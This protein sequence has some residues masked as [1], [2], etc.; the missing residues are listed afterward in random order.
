VIKRPGGIRFD[1]HRPA[2]AAP[3]SGSGPAPGWYPRG[4]DTA[5]ATSPDGQ[6]V[7]V[8]QGAVVRLFTLA[9]E[10]AGVATL[11]S[12]DADLAIVGPPTT[13]VVIERTGTGEGGLGGETA[14]IALAVPGLGE[15]ARIVVDGAHD[16]AATTG[17]RLALIARG[18]RALGVLRA[19]GRAFMSQLLDAGG[20]V[21]LAAGLDRNQ[22][23][24]VLAKRLEVW[25]AVSGRPLLRPTFTLP[26]APRRIGAAVGHAW[27]FQPGGTELVLYRLSDGRPFAHRLGS[28]IVSVASHPASP[29]L[30]AETA[31][32]LFRVQAFAHS[33]DR[34]TAPPGEAF[35][36]AGASTAVTAV[37]PTGASAAD[38]KLVG[39]AATG[40]PWWQPVV[41]D[42]P[43]EQAPPPSSSEAMEQIRAARE[44]RAQAPGR[45]TPA[46]GPGA[47]W[48]EPLVAFAAELHGKDGDRVA[49]VP[50]LALGTSLSDLCQRAQLSTPARRALTVLYACY[51]TGE[52]ALPIARLATLV[53]GDD[54]WREALATG[55]LAE[56]GLVTT[57]AGMIAVIDPI[58][59]VIDGAAPRTIDVVGDGPASIV[60]GAHLVDP[61]RLG[62]PLAAMTRALGRFAL[63]TGPLSIAVLEAF[64][65]GLT[66]VV[67]AGPTVRLRPVRV[68]RG[69]GLL[70]VA[71]V[72]V[73]PPSM[74]MWP[75]LSEGR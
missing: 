39:A 31:G 36:I 65:H 1:L 35:G 11:A 70:V 75:T 21:E 67:I 17:P 58:A 63:V 23:L 14:A 9:G 68:P 16:L 41:S 59:R 69:A 46:H 15:T 4:V 3:G 19:V 45:E 66:A 48:R 37:A 30:V 10:A 26:P 74:A 7:V 43:G 54:G 40:D 51:L 61:L 32:G 8:R 24:L 34:I 6:W 49:E 56:R 60:A 18:T 44:P 73:L 55:E 53:G 27:C 28:P 5:I 52:P 12:S 47:S 22:L 25:D 33:T 29:Y 71:P 20:P 38:L 72:D 64:A 13:V 2:D 50:A 62:E 57:R 42:G